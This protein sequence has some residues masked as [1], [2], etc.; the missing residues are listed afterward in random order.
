MIKTTAV[1]VSLSIMTAAAHAQPMVVSWY[2]E[3]QKMANGERFRPGDPTIAAHKSWPLGTRIRVYSP[4]TKKSLDMTVQD[5]GPYI[6]G[7]SL[8]VSQ[9]AAAVLGLFGPGVATLEVERLD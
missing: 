2:G 1:V 9:A 7:R 8:D 5:R 3:P 4:I 6:R